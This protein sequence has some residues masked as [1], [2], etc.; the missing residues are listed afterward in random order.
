MSD[1][2]P[3]DA[4]VPL[5][6]KSKASK[7]L[8]KTTTGVLSL[9]VA[10]I[11]I[12][13]IGFLTSIVVVRC[14]SQDHYAV[15]KQIG[16]LTFLFAVFSSFSLEPIVSRYLPEYLSK[17]KWSAV[18]QLIKCVMLMKSVILILLL[19]MAGT[20][21]KEWLFAFF[22]LSDVIRQWYPL[23]A[24][25]VALYLMYNLFGRAV[26]TASL[27]Q[28]IVSIMDVVEALLLLTSMT[29]AL[30]FMKA[31]IAGIILS[32]F[33]TRCIIFIVYLS[34]FA[35]R[36]LRIIQKNKETSGVPI[37]KTDFNR[38]FRFG[39]V[40]ACSQQIS[41]LQT[42][43][44]DVLAVSHYLPLVDVGLYG[45]AQIIPGLFMRFSP[46]RMLNPVVSPLIVK[47]YYA[48]NNSDVLEF[49]FSFLNKVNM[50]IL[51]P[52]LAV[53]LMFMDKILVHVFRPEYLD[54]MP[55]VWVLSACFLVRAF[56]YPYDPHVRILEKNKIVFV[57]SLLAFYNVAMYV[58]LI[59]RF[60]I[61]GA[62][63]ATG[64]TG[65]LTFL[66]YWALLRF[67]DRIKPAFPWLAFGKVCLNTL[68]MCLVL[69]VARI[70]VDSA[71]SV[72][73]ALLLAGLVYLGVSYLNKVFS[74]QDRS[75]LNHAIG[76]N[77]WVF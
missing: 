10:K 56:I 15:Y 36:I 75:M 64:S 49:S 35:N 34:L 44:V 8:R 66:V 17:Q 26:F 52:L 18:L 60:G 14:L 2:S 71:W 43:D 48:E 7:D 9:G 31:G 22:N 41:F 73:A 11:L 5:K 58:I 68:S 45:F 65:V 16:A 57:A 70:W 38:M 77:V 32:M 4:G 74:E 76:R 50:F 29:V 21:F 28:Y 53:V 40:R 37:Q 20:V 69:W 42:V 59:P 30:L 6:K 67:C 51:I 24:T 55:V 3:K 47:R 72:C 1:Y 25:V 62:A 61:I 46:A 23:I 13:G 33:I 12:A 19:V 27:D 63:I 54:A 39:A